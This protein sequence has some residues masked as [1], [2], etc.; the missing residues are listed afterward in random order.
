VSYLGRISGAGRWIVADR[1]VGHSLRFNPE[2]PIGVD[3]GQLA[4]VDGV[5]G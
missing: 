4:D 5:A 2:L 1:F 3:N